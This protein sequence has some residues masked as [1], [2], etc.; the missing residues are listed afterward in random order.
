[1]IKL[2]PFPSRYN[3][4][5]TLHKNSI[6]SELNIIKEKK[7]NPFEKRARDDKWGGTLIIPIQSRHF[8]D[9]GQLDTKGGDG[10]LLF[11]PHVYVLY[12]NV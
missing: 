2:Q 8:C 3:W 9:I 6:P 1:M 10:V 12:L 4:F 5:I 7:K 11:H